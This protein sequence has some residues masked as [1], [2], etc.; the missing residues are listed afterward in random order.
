MMIIAWSVS[1]M[2]PAALAGFFIV[3]A[4]V[5][6]KFILVTRAGYNQGFA[7][8]HIPSRGTATSI[9]VGEV[10][11]GWLTGRGQNEVTRGA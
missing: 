5:A 3:G 6:L 7:L 4:G 9:A 11:P 8:P 10:R 2:A 1:S